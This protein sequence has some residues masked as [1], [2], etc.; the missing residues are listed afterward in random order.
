MSW[1]DFGMPFYSVIDAV[2]RFEDDIL[3]LEPASS[4][5]QPSERNPMARYLDARLFASTGRTDEAIAMLGKLQSTSA[6]S[7]A[8]Q[9]ALISILLKQGDMPGALNAAKNLVQSKPESYEAHVALGRVYMAMLEKNPND[10]E[11]RANTIRAFETARKL[12]PNGM[13]ALASLGDLYWLD[14]RQSKNSAEEKATAAKVIEIYQKVLEL[15][16]GGDRLLPLLYL[17]FTHQIAG[18]LAEAEDY[19]NKA[20]AIEP[21]NIPAYLQLAGLYESQK[22]TDKVVETL[23]KALVIEPGAVS[24]QERLNSLL[25]AQSPEALLNFYRDLADDFKSSSEMQKLYAQQLV[26]QKKLSAAVD[27]YKRITELDKLDSDSRVLLAHLLIQ[28]AKIQ[29]AIPIIQ[30]LESLSSAD[31][32]MLNK[33][34]TLYL[35]ADMAE[36]A[37]RVYQE[38]VRISAPEEKFKYLSFLIAFH[39]H[40]KQPEK[41]LAAI[42]A[43]AEFLDTD[44]RYQLHLERARV[45]QD[46]DRI[47]EAETTLKSLIDEFA[48]KP[49]AYLQLGLLYDTAG[50]DAEAEQTYRDLLEK[51]PQKAEA[52]IG[53][54]MLYESSG[55]DELAEASYQKI[56]TFEPNNVEALLALGMLYDRM[57]KVPEAEKVYRK[58]IELD[59]ENADALNNL[60][61]LYAARG[62]NLDEAQKLIEKAMALSPGA[63]HIIDSMGWVMYQQ[64]KYEEAVRYLE[65][66]AA[67]S[68]FETTD[69]EV[70]EHL[71]DAYLKLGRTQEALA[72]YKKALRSDPSRSK[73]AEKVVELEQAPATSPASQP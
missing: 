40:K 15:S 24:V 41:A 72:V 4:P 14:F 37:E 68:G 32:E 9:L 48:D 54:G 55:K 1:R 27:V 30:E 6:P 52:Y 25:L 20:I 51:M 39:L 58:A 49:P 21:R 8:P 67:Q 34:A 64:G 5:S 65:A 16:R 42:D 35:E 47:D 3:A 23:R 70:Y 11:S 69:A 12:Q 18:K 53:L 59:P 45:L 29:Q 19:F 2:P 36:D 57:D 33:A 7:L 28:Q 56:L 50:R 26:E 71:G 62:R 13:E 61:Y 31:P 60:G 46:L 22:K 10:S 66:A 17:A 38:T 63:A 43:E 73:T 44:Q